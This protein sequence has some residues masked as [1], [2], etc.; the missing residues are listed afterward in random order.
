MQ[1]GGEARP[2]G[3]L[4]LKVVRGDGSEEHIRTYEQPTPWPITT[5]LATILEHASPHPHLAPEV[6]E[7]RRA[8]RVN[9]RFPALRI[10]ATAS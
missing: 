9:L 7:W 4:A 3:S 2:S 6:N 8:N 5:R 1:L 10:L